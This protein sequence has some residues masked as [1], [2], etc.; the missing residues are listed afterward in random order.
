MTPSVHSSNNGAGQAQGAGMSLDDV[1][2]TLFR[3]KRL[4][5]AF[6]LVG[7][8]PELCAEPSRSI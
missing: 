4:I 8:P 1:L 6:L 2:F 5:I 7:L 3:H